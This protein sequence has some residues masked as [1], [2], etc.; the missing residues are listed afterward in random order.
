MDCIRWIF[1]IPC[2][3]LLRLNVPLTEIAELELTTALLPLEHPIFPVMSA[4]TDVAN[5][6][7]VDNCLIYVP[8]L[9]IARRS[10]GDEVCQLK[11]NVL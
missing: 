8:P 6:A 11:L 10:I 1:S 9:L 4:S 5:I 3:L 2:E 7:R